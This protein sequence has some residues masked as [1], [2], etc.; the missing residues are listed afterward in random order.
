MKGGHFFGDVVGAD[1]SATHDGPALAR[2]GFPF[3]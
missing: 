3:G 1:L 2:H